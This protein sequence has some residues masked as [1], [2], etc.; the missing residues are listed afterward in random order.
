MGFGCR[1][2]CI[3]PTNWIG[4][5]NT[6]CFGTAGGRNAIHD[7]DTWLHAG[8]QHFGWIGAGNQWQGQYQTLEVTY[9][10]PPRRRF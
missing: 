10:L 7:V 9:K 4:A 5:N 6:G 2:E 1:V 8:E 3:S